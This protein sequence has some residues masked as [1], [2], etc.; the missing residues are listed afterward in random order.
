MHIHKDAKPLS[1]TLCTRTLLP[2]QRLG[3]ALQ[4][5]MVMMC[6]KSR[7]SNGD[8]PWKIPNRDVLTLGIHLRYASN[9]DGANG[10]VPGKLPFQSHPHIGNSSV[11][12]ANLIGRLT[13]VWPG[14]Q[15]IAWKRS[16]VHQLL[17]VKQSTVHLIP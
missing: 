16:M 9:S 13:P 11:N 17:H 3:A 4:S 10:D 2:A 15:Q 12:A 6:T 8:V 5:L 1:A 14:N 7:W